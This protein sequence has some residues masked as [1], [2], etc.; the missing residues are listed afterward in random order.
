MSETI[1]QRR[2]KSRLRMAKYRDEDPEKMNA[3]QRKWR[4][5][6]LDQSRKKERDYKLAHPEKRKE[7]WERWYAEHK[8][9]IQEKNRKR[10]GTMR[11]KIFTHY[12]G[13]DP[14]CICCGEMHSEFL[15]VDHINGGG[16]KH[17][18]QI[19]QGGLYGWLI[20]NNFPDGFRILCLNCNW[21]IGVRGYCP[22]Q[23]TGD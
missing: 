9:L 12:G 4:S 20:K 5:E 14:H 19:G 21:S 8:D 13:P 23:K 7:W 10:Q 11:Q 18:E 2:E 6:H 15:T 17:R 1:E 3:Y 22:H 16:N